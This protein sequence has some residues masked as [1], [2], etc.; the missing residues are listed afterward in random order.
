MTCVRRAWLVLGAQSID[1]EDVSAGYVCTSLDIGSPEVRDVTN[2]RPDANGIDDRTQ[3][4]G[5]RPV[6]ADI[7]VAAPDA[8]IDEVA[9][10]FA[11][12][13]VPNVRPELHYVLDRGTNPERVLVL[14]AADYGWRVQG[15]I[16]RE[17]HLQW[18]AA[19]PIAYDPAVRTA[20][21]WAGSSGASGRVYNLT[22]PRAY[23][24]G[25]TPPMN[26]QVRTNGDVSVRPVLRIYGPIVQPRVQLADPQNNRQWFA[27]RNTTTIDANHFIDIDMGARTAYW[28]GDR[29]RSA[30]R[31]INWW[32]PTTWFLLAPAV[33]YTMTLFADGGGSGQ[34][35]Q[36]VLSWRDGFVS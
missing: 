10:A 14:R 29:T 9:S 5:S 22:F 18:V 35:T 34:A 33:Q 17:V 12:F 1:L 28:D 4:Y 24:V 25:T 8:R 32:Y 27:L 15:P 19:D 6:T 36:A 2:N 20:T 23:P 11:P 13:M 16:T 30:M 3:F 21:S 31:E 26:A 7:V